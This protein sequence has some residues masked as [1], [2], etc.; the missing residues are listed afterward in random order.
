MK[1]N[2]A[3]G[4]TCSKLGSDTKVSLVWNLVHCMAKVLQK[5]RPLKR[6]YYIMELLLWIVKGNM[7]AKTFQL[8]HVL[9]WFAKSKHYCTNCWKTSQGSSS[10]CCCPHQGL[11]VTTGCRHNLTWMGKSWPSM[12]PGILQC[13]LQGWIPVFT[14]PGRWQTVCSIFYLQGYWLIIAKAVVVHTHQLT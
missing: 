3:A 11:D 14:E 13:S 4:K 6:F 10:G 9:N 8:I 5:D 1:R 7:L 2:T 12:V